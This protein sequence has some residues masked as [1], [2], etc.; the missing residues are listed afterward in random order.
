METSVRAQ[1]SSKIKLDL[2]I[3]STQLVGKKPF[4]ELY[5]DEICEK[6]NVS[7][8]TF[9]K[10]FPQKEDVLLFFLRIWCLD[11][12]IELHHEPKE[13]MKGIHYLL[14]K[15][16]E[17]YNKNPGIILSLISYVTSLQR[18]PSPF[19]LKSIEREMLYPNDDAVK[20]V[21]I[22]SIDQ[23]LDKFLLE[24]IFKGE[25][26]GVSDTKDLTNLFQAVIYGSIVTAHM[27]QIESLKLFF[28][29]NIDTVLKKLGDT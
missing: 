15:L 2:L 6:A 13:G 24:A 12:A 29:Q 1:K 8:V 28:R 3:A 22:L 21:E 19:P 17:T 27:R 16:A 5:V 11:R 7:K 26:V 10:Y 20:T 18:P 9:F 25:I 14:D 23:M 4:R